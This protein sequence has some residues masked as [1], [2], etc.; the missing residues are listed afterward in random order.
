MLDQ[1]YGV[2]ITTEIVNCSK[3][4]AS[5]CLVDGISIFLMASTFLWS[6]FT[7]SGVYLLPKKLYDLHLT[8]HLS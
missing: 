8:I 6:G 3:N 2:Y 5:A 1:R 4:D 7:P